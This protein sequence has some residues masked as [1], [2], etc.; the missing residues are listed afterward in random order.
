MKLKICGVNINLSYPLA[1][2]V[3]LLLV[4]DTT[5]AVMCGLCA[6]VMHELGHISAMKFFGTRI[7]DIRL[8]VFDIGITDISKSRR[9]I[10]AEITIILSG[11]FVNL[12]LFLLSYML[13]NESRFYIFRYFA[14]ANLTLGLFNALPVETLDG[15]EALSLIL[16]RYFSEKAVYIITLVLSLAVI[17]P[18]GYLSVRALLNSVYNFTLLFAVLYLTGA[19]VFRIMSPEK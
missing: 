16:R 3:T 9:S 10:T 5:G 7:T 8:S 2:G 15:G 19:V 17:V 11:I 14:L 12:V 4:C 1:A 18:L 6:S 13:Y